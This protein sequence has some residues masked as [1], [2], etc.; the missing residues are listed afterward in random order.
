MTGAPCPPAPLSLA[1]NRWHGSMM[2]TQRLTCDQ[3][4]SP[5]TLWDA[6]RRVSRGGERSLGVLVAVLVP[7][8][9]QVL[10][11]VRFNVPHKQIATS[12]PSW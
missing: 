3:F 9:L 5:E 7:G 1:R 2:P 4:R 12:V 10:Q 11:S 6:R 8:A